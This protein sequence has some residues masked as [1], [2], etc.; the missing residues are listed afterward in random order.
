MALEKK[1][2]RSMLR[3]KV[4]EGVAQAC[5]LSTS[6]VIKIQHQA[7]CGDVFH[8]PA[9]YTSSWAQMDDFDRQAIRRFVH[10][11]YERHE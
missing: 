5:Q 3:M 11:F 9:K 2:G 1:A 10:G 7:K 8:T 4:V 6:T